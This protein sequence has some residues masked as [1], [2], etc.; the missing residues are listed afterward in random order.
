MWCY[1]ST[2][3]VDRASICWVHMW[4]FNCETGGSK[5]P[6]FYP[7]EQLVEGLKL[8]VHKLKTV[9]RKTVIWTLKTPLGKTVGFLYLTLLAPW[10]L[11]TITNTVI[12]Q[13]QV[14][15]VNK[16][17]SYNVHFNALMGCICG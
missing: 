1:E 11:F 16:W 17:N 3:C 14:Q 15:Q 8:E 6:G 12:L 9:T 4:A 10:G 13:L 7:D 5:N 2:Y